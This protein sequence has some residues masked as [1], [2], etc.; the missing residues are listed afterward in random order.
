MLDV[1]ITV[2]EFIDAIETQVNNNDLLES[3]DESS[4]CCCAFAISDNCRT[5]LLCMPGRIEASL[6]C[7]SAPMLD[8][9][10]AL[11][12]NI[13]SRLFSRVLLRLDYTPRAWRAASSSHGLY[14]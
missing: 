10:A 1:V 4:I 9:F 3:A 2:D 8:D 7:L 14:Q 11:G 13:E 12:A 6:A 5:I